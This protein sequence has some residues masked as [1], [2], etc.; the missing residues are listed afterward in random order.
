MLVGYTSIQ[1]AGTFALR[2]VS[3]F[4]ALDQYNSSEL[5]VGKQIP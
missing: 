1:F 2:I 3:A 4:M 5:L